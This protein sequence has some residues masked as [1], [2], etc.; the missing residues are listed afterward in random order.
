MNAGKP[1]GLVRVDMKNAGVGVGASQHLSMKH[2]WQREI[3]G[4]FGFPGGLDDSVHPGKP[5]ADIYILPFHFPA[6][7][8]EAFVTASMIFT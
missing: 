4:V 2:A 3:A 5:L 6:S 7:A 8:R 1:L